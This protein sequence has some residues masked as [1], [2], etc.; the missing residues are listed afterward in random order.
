MFAL[1]VGLLWQSPAW[2]QCRN[3]MDCRG[4]RVCSQGSC[5]YAKCTMDVECPN[6]GVCVQNQCRATAVTP[7]TSAPAP[8]VQ[9]VRRRRLR[10]GRP[11]KTIPDGE[12]RTIRRPINGLWIPGVVILG[13]SYALGIGITSGADDDFVGLSA[14]PLAGPFIIAAQKDNR[15]LRDIRGISILTGIV[16]LASLTM[17][18]LGLAIKRTRYIPLYTLSDGEDPPVL[19]V[20]PSVV[21]RGGVGVT[22]NVLNY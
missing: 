7:G 16:Q 2:A 10:K 20:L 1:L 6:N 19:A 11:Q 5:T 22:M 15:Q 17:T 18:T 14:I 12:Y 9:K 3:D 4:L 13:V 8:T 21:G